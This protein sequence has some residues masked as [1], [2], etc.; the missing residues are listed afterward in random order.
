L[1]GRALP[2]PPNSNGENSAHQLADWKK[3]ASEWSAQ[4]LAAL[5]FTASPAAGE[6]YWAKQ[7]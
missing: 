3:T 6:P 4:N 7:K 1:L 5:V 2:L